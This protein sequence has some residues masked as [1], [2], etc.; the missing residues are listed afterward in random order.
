M[1]R[2]ARLADATEIGLP[3]VSMS[4]LMRAVRSASQGSPL[5]CKTGGERRRDAWPV[6]TC[7]LLRDLAGATFANV[8]RLLGC[9]DGAAVR[10]NQ[11]HR[12]LLSACQAYQ[13]ACG[14]VAASCLRSR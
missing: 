12:R 9:T 10:R 1:Q 7:G 5:R 14:R 2:K 3:Y 13:E 11:Q 4:K 6:L 8:R